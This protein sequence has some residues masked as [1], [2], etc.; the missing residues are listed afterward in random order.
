MLKNKFGR[1]GYSVDNGGCIRVWMGNNVPAQFRQLGRLRDFAPL[2]GENGPIEHNGIIVVFVAHVP[3]A[4]LVSPVYQQGNWGGE[5]S[6]W[7][8]EGECG[9][10]GTNALDVYPHPDG[11]GI[12]IVG[13]CV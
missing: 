10:F 11:D 3:A 5:N 1:K 12:L 4:V 8:R 13:S 2:D 9:L 7:M 6:G